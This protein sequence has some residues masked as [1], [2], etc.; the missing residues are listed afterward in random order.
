[1]PIPKS[2]HTVRV[3]TVMAGMVRNQ[4]ASLPPHP[5]GFEGAAVEEAARLLGYN[6]TEDTYGLKAKAVKA[7]SA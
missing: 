3:L 5:S 2:L 4:Y 1:M 6:D 7:L